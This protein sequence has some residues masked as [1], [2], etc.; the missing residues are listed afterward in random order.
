[1]KRIVSQTW[2]GIICVILGFMLTFQFKANYST[3]NKTTARQY[4]DVAQELESI[5]KQKDDLSAKVKEYQDKVNEYETAAASVSETASMMKKEL[6]NLRIQ[7]GLIDVTGPGIVITISLPGDVTQAGTPGD[8]RYTD[9]IDIVNELNA[10]NKAEAISINDERYTSRTQ[11]RPVGNVIKIND[12]KMDPAQPF[13]IKAIG[14]PTILYGAFKM[15]GNILDYISG[16]GYEV[17]MEKMDSVKV[18]KY[19]RPLEFKYAK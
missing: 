9:L 17:K 15:P 1:M 16:D 4:E 2:I 13:V 12:T 8:I 5:K 14:D 19:N 11:I 3:A 10:T 6:E 7:A 18:L